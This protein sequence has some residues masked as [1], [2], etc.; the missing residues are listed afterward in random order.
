MNSEK[1]DSLE[2]VK[3][4]YAFSLMCIRDLI[5]EKKRELSIT[6]EFLDKLE[7]DENEMRIKL[8]KLE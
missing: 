4:E 2:R 1:K 7:R 6:L 8:E 5:Q 3:E